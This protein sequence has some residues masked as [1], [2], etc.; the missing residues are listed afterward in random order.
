M[1]KRMILKRLHLQEKAESIRPRGTAR[2]TSIEKRYAYLQNTTPKKQM[3][4]KQ[5]TKLLHRI[6][7]IANWLDNAVPH[8]P[9]PLGLDSLLSFIPFIGGFIGAI[10]TAYQVYLSTLFGIPLWLLTRMLVNLTIDLAIGSI[11]MVGAFADMFYKANLWNYEALVDW[12][13]QDTATTAPGAATTSDQASS[14]T[15]H[16]TAKVGRELTW[17]EIFRDATHMY[18]AVL[19]F[20]PFTNFDSEGHK[21]QS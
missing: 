16:G 10:F 21:K 9:I 11:P 7:K 2:Q 18:T 5:R 13:D 12:L 20:I 8:S 4:E 6:E 1:F 14:S 17:T 3:S 15:A 19:T